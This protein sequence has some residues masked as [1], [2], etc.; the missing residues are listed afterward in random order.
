VHE[1]DILVASL[2]RRAAKVKVALDA[3]NLDEA[4]ESIRAGGI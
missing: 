4:R 3:D 2:T 1:K